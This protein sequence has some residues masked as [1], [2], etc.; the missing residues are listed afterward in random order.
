RRRG[1]HS[2]PTRLSSDLLERLGECARGGAQPL[3]QVDDREL[4]DPPPAPL[5]GSRPVIPLLLPGR[6]DEA[7]PIEPAQEL[8]GALVQVRLRS[9][10]HTSELQSLRHLV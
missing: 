5:P 10:E 8:R 6:L 2:F 7:F 4:D 3:A 1:L 9:E